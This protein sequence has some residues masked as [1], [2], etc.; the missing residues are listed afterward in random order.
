MSGYQTYKTVKT[1][2]V[3]AL[4]VAAALL[5]LSPVTFAQSDINNFI[6][7]GL[8]DANTLLNAYAA[9][10]GKSTG[11]NMNAGWINTAAPLKPGRFE[12][13]LVGNVAYVPKSERSYSLD[14]L[15]LGTPTT[16][17]VA[18]Q[19]V[20][21]QWQYQFTQVPTVFG[22]AENSE[23]IRKVVTYQN[24]NSSTQEVA[25]LA[26]IELPDGAGLFI[27][28]LA[29]AMQLSVGVPMGTEVMI[30]FLPATDVNSNEVALN[31]DGL[32]GLG[33]KHNVKQWI[34]GLRN[35]P[36][37]LAMAFGYSTSKASLELPTLLPTAPIGE[38]FADSSL[39]NTGYQGPSVDDA[40]YSGQG[41]DFRVHAWNVNVLISK[42]LPL[43]SFY[44]GLRYARSSTEV[45]L[46]GTYGFASVPYYNTE[47]T[48]DPNNRKLTLINVED[49]I[50]IKT[51]HGQASLVGGFRFKLGF[52]ALSGEAALSRFPTASVGISAGWM[53]LV[54]ARR[55]VKKNLNIW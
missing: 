41:A 6:S 50:Q 35:L 13:K 25:T 44:G 27:N 47:Q 43:L 4:A 39:A 36:F 30:R 46:T 11:A 49:P 3:K 1:N 32:W 7:G 19:E 2:S 34:P 5:G 31:Y 52:L 42:E 55:G 12:L 37:S 16:R 9:P 22:S 45:N 18:G 51:S 10:L 26:E 20:T 14:K 21:E 29:P 48:F 8:E 53:D 23:T 28:P 17:T 33:V 38:A 24:P 15:G 40:D 54:P